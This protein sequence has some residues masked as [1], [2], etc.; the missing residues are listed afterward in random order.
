MHK[1]LIWYI[2][3]F[4]VLLISLILFFMLLFTI[5]HQTSNQMRDEAVL[6]QQTFLE[7]GAAEITNR[8]DSY[9]GNRIFQLQK[10]TAFAE[11]GAVNTTPV[12]Y[13]HM[14]KLRDEVKRVMGNFN[15]DNPFMIV[16]A[17]GDGLAISP[18]SIYHNLRES[19][20]QHNL[21]FNNLDFDQTIDFLREVAS[22]G[23]IVNRVSVISYSSRADNLCTYFEQS[24]IC[25]VRRLKA[26]QESSEIYALWLF[27]I[28]SLNA[29]L[30]G[31]QETS[32]F[33]ALTQLD[34]VL[35]ASVSDVPITKIGLTPQ[36]DKDE[37]NTYFSVPLPSL[38][39]TAYMAVSDNV[40]LKQLSRFST[41][42]YILLAAFIMLFAALTVMLVFY[43][44]KPLWKLYARVFPYNES[45]SS[46]PGGNII[47]Q[48]E[49]RVVEMGDYHR[50]QE[51]KISQWQSMLHKNLLSKLLQGQQIT[52]TEA[53]FLNSLPGILP[54]QIFRV[55][56]IGMF[57]ERPQQNTDFSTTL[58]NSLQ[59]ALGTPLYTWMDSR[60]IALVLPEGDSRDQTP[61]MQQGINTLLTE[62]HATLSGRL[63]DTNALAFGVGSGY[64]GIKQIEQSYKEAKGAFREAEMWQK[65]SVIFFEANE[66]CDLSY[67]I[68]YSTLERIQNLL[69]AGK[70][71]EAARVLDALSD[72]LFGEGQPSRF[73]ERVAQQFYHDVYGMVMR[74]A[75]RKKELSILS[76]FPGYDDTRPI[77][78]W[79]EEINFSFADVVEV[80]VN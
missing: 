13:A 63:N 49:G 52:P 6:R 37:R 44:A 47:T 54:L 29:S 36:Y 57:S 56:I 80:I 74:M 40:I 23:Y 27:D 43:F 48:I 66:T 67:T 9:W 38:N 77:L 8:F 65:A 20:E 42:W 73:D 1:N 18:N 39:L 33:F 31:G 46:S 60:Q 34:K 41:L 15:E 32:D 69:K 3:L 75:S 14:I 16:F 25:V 79:L 53:A 59:E 58:E 12:C 62:L 61:R 17:E 2:R 71:Q 22:D 4:S 70:A 50:E 45:L 76:S 72:Q 24:Y 28:N 30:S 11:L 21:C 10:T 35:H 5:Y 64:R 19:V 68:P 7:R 78:L 51:Q 26:S 55:V